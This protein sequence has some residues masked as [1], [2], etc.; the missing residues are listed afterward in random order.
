MVEKGI[1]CSGICCCYALPEERE[2]YRARSRHQL[3][4]GGGDEETAPEN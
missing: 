1:D 2:N 4:G 3:G